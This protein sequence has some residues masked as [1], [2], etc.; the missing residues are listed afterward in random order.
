MDISKEEQEMFDLKNKIEIEKRKLELE[1]QKK[2]QK[3]G[4]IEEQQDCLHQLVTEKY[5]LTQFS[6]SR[7][8]NQ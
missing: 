1:V 7:W 8:N 5:K 2:Y 3:I 6:I 4:I